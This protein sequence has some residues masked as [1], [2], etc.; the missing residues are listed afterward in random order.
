LNDVGGINAIEALVI[1]KAVDNLQ[2][3]LKDVPVK[4]LAQYVK[5]NRDLS[6]EIPMNFT[7]P[8]IVM[9]FKKQLISYLKNCDA[10]KYKQL[11]EYIRISL[12]R[13]HPVHSELLGL[14]SARGWYYSNMDRIK[15][16]IIARLEGGIDDE[17]YGNSAVG[18]GDTG[19][20]GDAGILLLQQDQGLS[21][22][23][24]TE[25]EFQV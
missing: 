1:N 20:S 22:D 16:L 21:G 10:N 12:S 13:Y 7:V 25:S 3:Y 15:D 6:K 24:F 9:K 18:G 8:G 4:Q 11:Y 17:K 5:E 14:N 23:S 19:G 2:H